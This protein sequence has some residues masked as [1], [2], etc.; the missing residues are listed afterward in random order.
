M[1]N[2][3]PGKRKKN[4]NLTPQERMAR[5]QR[6]KKRRATQPGK[7]FKP[8]AKKAVPLSD[9][10]H[11]HVFHATIENARA[12]AGVKPGYGH[13]VRGGHQPG[14]H[15]G[16]QGT[17]AQ[18]RQGQT[19]EE[20]ARQYFDSRIQEAGGKAVPGTDAYRQIVRDTV[21]FT[22]IKYPGTEGHKAVKTKEAGGD[23]PPHPDLES[24]LSQEPE[25][26]S[27]ASRIFTNPN[28]V[29]GEQVKVRKETKDEVFDKK[30]G[31]VNTKEE[32]RDKAGSFSSDDKTPLGDITGPPKRM[33]KGVLRPNEF[34]SSISESEREF[35]ESEMRREGS[36][37]FAATTK[38]AKE[39]GRD[40]LDSASYR[41]LQR[42][43]AYRQE[44]YPQETIYKHLS[45]E[46]RG[47][48]SPTASA[49][50]TKTRKQ[51]EAGERVEGRQEYP[52]TWGRKKTTDIPGQRHQDFQF[53]KQAP[54]ISTSA[55]LRAA[56]PDAS[57]AEIARMRDYEREYLTED[58]LEANSAWQHEE[59]A[60]KYNSS[61]KGEGDKVTVFTTSLGA[62][63]VSVPAES[64]LGQ[65]VI[66]K[67]K[68]MVVDDKQHARYEVKGSFP[69]AVRD[70]HIIEAGTGVSLGAQGQYGLYKNTGV[71]RGTKRTKGY[72]M[73]V[74]VGATLVRDA[75]GRPVYDKDGNPRYSEGYTRPFAA[76]TK[77][78]VGFRVFVG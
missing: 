53:S 75:W 77:K 15:A 78:S 22:L 25:L 41:N 1:A 11:P 28:Y 74:P 12:D 60:R 4:K 54:R 21:M 23:A 39:S 76:G 19:P 67:R 29:F 8:G 59:K 58:V 2:K 47:R 55:E 73:E 35:I 49:G 71:R 31:R 42:Y 64:F 48:T 66:K 16:S 52:E 68:K 40:K 27:A 5:Q 45:K 17:T 33:G 44:K 65:Y 50:G 57:D 34:M 37:L 70:K 9:K 30:L 3:E 6:A 10:T 69:N 56:N 7:G 62:P 13:P 46:T 43:I 63:S 72:G 24:S 26:L 32:W 36:P 61:P 51:K 18:F 38:S 14:A 20:Y